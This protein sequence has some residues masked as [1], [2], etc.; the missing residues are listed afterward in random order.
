MLATQS[1][2]PVKTAKHI[3]AKISKFALIT[4]YK[5]IFESN[6]KLLKALKRKGATKSYTQVLSLF[7]SELDLFEEAYF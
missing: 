2:F 5:T 6:F 3:K 1:Y 7:F 4:D